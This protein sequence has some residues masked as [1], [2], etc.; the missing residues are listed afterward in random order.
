MIGRM[1]E[2]K[3]KW[4]KIEAFISGIMKIKENDEYE[5]NEYGSV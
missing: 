3:E 2:S 5:L 1:T 4:G